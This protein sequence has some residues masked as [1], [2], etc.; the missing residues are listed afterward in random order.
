M[1]HLKPKFEQIFFRLKPKLSCLPNR[2]AHLSETVGGFWCRVTHARYR[3]TQSYSYRVTVT[4]L[5]R[6]TCS[7]IK[8]TIYVWP[9]WQNHW[10]FLSAKW[11]PSSLKLSQVSSLQLSVEKK[12][13]TISQVKYCPKSPL[14]EIADV[15]ISHLKL[16]RQKQICEIMKVN[17]LLKL[18]VGI[19]KV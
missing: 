14:P 18:R 1:S 9:L 17:F 6:Y 5:Q 8:N 3:V 12:H 4:E 16:L 11:L 7:S 19:S 2:G 13:L 15:S 10:L